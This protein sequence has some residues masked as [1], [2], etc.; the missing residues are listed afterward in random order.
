MENFIKDFISVGVYTIIHDTT[1]T[2]LELWLEEQENKG[3]K[4]HKV[5]DIDF[6][7]GVFWIENCPYGVW[8]TDNFEVVNK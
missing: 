8:F 7:N 6:D 2:D 1:D 4:K 3:I 5:I